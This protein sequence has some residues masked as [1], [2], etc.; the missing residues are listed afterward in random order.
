M[1]MWMMMITN[2]AAAASKRG[3]SHTFQWADHGVRDVAAKLVAAMLVVAV[4]F[5]SLELS[6]SRQPAGEIAARADFTASTARHSPR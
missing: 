4:V 2:H 6:G 1:D 5:A 3:G